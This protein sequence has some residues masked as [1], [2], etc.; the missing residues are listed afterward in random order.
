MSG[1]G[2]ESGA[3]CNCDHEFL[4]IYKNYLFRVITVPGGSK[5]TIPGEQEAILGPD[6]NTITN[7]SGVAI[8][9]D[10]GTPFLTLSI[11]SNLNL[12]VQSSCCI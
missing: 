9:V 7:D 12:T 4:N 3:S 2:L 11:A 5:L 1:N 8:G 6:G 10:Q